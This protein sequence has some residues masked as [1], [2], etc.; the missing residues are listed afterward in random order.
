MAGDIISYCKHGH[1][2]TPANIYVRPGGQVNCRECKRISHQKNRDIHPWRMSLRC[3][4]R[5]C[6][7]HK[8]YPAYAGKGIQVFLTYEEAKYLWFRDKASLMD[9]PSLDREDPDKNYSMDNCKF[10]ELRENIRKDKIKW[11][12]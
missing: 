1:L 3:A 2:M 7:D 11:K 4:R 8:N 12:S 10:M 6:R 9:R 5:R